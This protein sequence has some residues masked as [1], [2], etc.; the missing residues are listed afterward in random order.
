[1]KKQARDFCVIS[2]ALCAV[3]LWKFN[4]LLSFPV[5]TSWVVGLKEIEQSRWVSSF[6]S[7]WETCKKDIKWWVNILATH[8][9]TTTGP[10]RKR[11]LSVGW[12]L[13]SFTVMNK[14]WDVHDFEVNDEI[15]RLFSFP[16][17]LPKHTLGS[18]VFCFLVAFMLLWHILIYTEILHFHSAAAAAPFRHIHKLLSSHCNLAWVKRWV[19]SDINTKKKRKK[20]SNCEAWH[21]HVGGGLEGSRT[22]LHHSSSRME[23]GNTILS[24]E[25]FSHSRQLTL[26]VDTCWATLEFGMEQSRKCERGGRNCWKSHQ[27]RKFFFR[28]R[29]D[30]DKCWI[31]IYQKRRFWSGEKVGS[32]QSVFW[33]Q[34]SFRRRKKFI[35]FS[36]HDT[37]KEYPDD[38][39]VSITD[40]TLI[41]SQLNAISIS[42]FTNL[43]ILSS[44]LHA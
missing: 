21:E 4:A 34:S 1:M 36:V 14:S 19:L 32:P 38:D 11:V 10:I 43:L 39:K 6:L 3:V 20:N 18:H 29:W 15:T 31:L 42:I 28:L 12:S 35:R 17:L 26:M 2:S 44:K 8:K 13:I 22:F 40:L 24:D 41:S 5:C 37:S 7:S 23:E 33:L 25:R 16:I 27:S 9:K 30:Q